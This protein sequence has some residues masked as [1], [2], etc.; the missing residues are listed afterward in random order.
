MFNIYYC[1]GKMAYIDNEKINQIRTSANIVDII[2]DY[3]SLTAKG[4]NFFGVC[5]FHDD[6]SPSMSVSPDKQIYTCFSC[7]ATGNVFTFVQNFD[8]ISFVEAVDKVA[9]KVG[10]N[11][12]IS[13]VNTK[14]K[15]LKIE[16]EILNYCQKYFTNNLNTE[17]GI[18]ARSY[19]NK[20]GI[21]DDLIDKFGIGL[22]INEKSALTKLLINKKFDLNVLL[23]I[24]LSAN[25]KD[26]LDTFHNRIM[27]PIWDAFGQIVGFSGRIYNDENTSKYV[28]SR[29]S[30]IFKK[31]EILYN[32]HHAKEEIRKEKSIIVVEGFMDV[33]RLS[34]VGINNV[35]ALMGTAMTNDQVN[36][37]KQLRTKVILCFDNDEAGMNAAITNG[38][39]LFIHKVDVSIIK[40][41]EE[42]DPDEYIIKKGKDNFVRKIENA[43]YYLDYRLKDLKQKINVDNTEEL[44]QGINE[45]IELINKVDD[46]ILRDLMIKNISEEF[47]LDEDIISLKVKKPIAQNQNQSKEVVNKYKPLKKKNRFDKASEGL[48]F[49]L[50]DNV[51]YLK[52]FEK[53]LG[54]FPQANY[55]DLLNEIRFYYERNNDINLA[56]FMSHINDNQ[57]L[58]DIMKEIIIDI[59]DK[60]IENNFDEYIEIIKVQIYQKRI[61]KLKKELSLA[62]DIDEKIAIAKKISEIKKGSVN[63]G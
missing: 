9:K 55:G 33:I 19:L 32:Y 34:S 22:T 44:A 52:Q 49:L 35:V 56:D 58:N 8:H 17:F 29:A 37:L 27:F 15:E 36:L 25:E 12:G 21:T 3:I 26:P 38:E 40:L 50:I 13:N 63:N 1:R 60:N 45:M 14:P 51:K 53:K 23:D 48:I 41:D 39:Q 43:I 31:G 24:G 16:F 61:E 47:K 59:G 4:R 20:R 7:G 30:S 42:K 54:Y 57:E 28:N 11:L 5:P 18:N 10:I 6:H 46:A 62:S 2:S